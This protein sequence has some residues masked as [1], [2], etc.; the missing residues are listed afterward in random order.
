M[1]RYSSKYSNVI[2]ELP[3]TPK[4][5]GSEHGSFCGPQQSNTRVV[6]YSYKGSHEVSDYQEWV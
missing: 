5:T 4:G 6:R 3:W 1:D 2:S